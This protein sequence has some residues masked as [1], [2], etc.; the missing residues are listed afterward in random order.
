VYQRS[1]ACTWQVLCPACERDVILD[2]KCLGP[3]CPIC[4][5]CQQPIDPATGRWVARNPTSR[6][7]HGFWINHVMAPWHSY[8][9]ILKRQAD[10]DPVR[11]RNEVLGLST[12]IG[13]HVVTRKEMEDC[14]GTYAMSTS[15]TR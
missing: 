4:S 3:V 12:Q 11:F 10:Y 15:F 1:T 2:E 9:N 6:W 8:S 7:G 13:D 5:H 14:C